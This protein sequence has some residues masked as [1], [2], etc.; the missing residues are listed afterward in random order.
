MNNNIINKNNDLISQRV[1]TIVNH[2]YINPYN[3]LND[4]Y[5]NN[6]IISQLK[7]KTIKE[8]DNMILIYNDL[9]LKFNNAQKFFIKK[10]LK[11]LTIKGGSK[12]KSNNKKLELEKKS[13]NKKLE[14]E[15]KSNI[16]KLENKLNICNIVKY[17]TLKLKKK[18]KYSYK[19][20]KK[21]INLI[22]PKNYN[23]ILY[24]EIYYLDDW[25]RIEQTRLNSCKYNKN[26][27]VYG[28]QRP[29][30]INKN[31][32]FNIMSI[33][34]YNYNITR[35]ITLDE[36]YSEK[37]VWK[38]IINMSTNKNSFE[39]YD[40]K[41]IDFTSYTPHNAYWLLNNLVK[42]NTNTL[43]HCTAG[44]GR[45]G[46]VI[47][48]QLIYE[49]IYSEMFELV[50]NHMVNKSNLENISKI[51]DFDINSNNI[52]NIYYNSLNEIYPASTGLYE[53]PAEEIFE[54]NKQLLAFRIN[55]IKLT[56]LLYICKNF[57]FKPK[58]ID[59]I[60]NLKVVMNIYFNSYSQIMNIT[61]KQPFYTYVEYI[62][63][64]TNNIKNIFFNI[65]DNELKNENDELNIL[66][67]YILI[68]YKN[69][70]NNKNNK[71]TK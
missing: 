41:I 12:E 67:K 32:M 34:V 23:N 35:Y 26:T 70:K 55:T 27:N 4:N 54:G 25:Q 21:I 16:K 28:M 51:L 57:N 17:T 64:S 36:N 31:Q 40:R 59:I 61:I 33:L 49:K 71:I 6:Y 37:I 65:S 63:D 9:L 10:N 60:M 7:V 68:I 30:Y 5:I 69:N 20:I 8:L 46:S 50:A 13:N 53:S 62:L 66:L 14:S 38:D 1:F 48:L 11:L 18:N 47:L 56:S 2:N 43:V 3:S 29:N 19:N 22:K 45:T 42:V 52:N 39:F 44:F 58:I 24:E 15:K